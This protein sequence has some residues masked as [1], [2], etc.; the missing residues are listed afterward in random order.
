MVDFDLFFDHKGDVGRL[1]WTLP[2]AVMREKE[3]LDT[4]LWCCSISDPCLR[5]PSHARGGDATPMAP[6][7][8][9]SCNLSSFVKTYR[10]RIWQLL[11]LQSLVTKQVIKQWQN[12]AAVASPDYLRSKFIMVY[13]KTYYRWNAS[14]GNGNCFCKNYLKL[15]WKY[16]DISKFI[17]FP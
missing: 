13:G 9:S 14:V 4:E 5:C 11:I 10:K 2:S 16:K 7:I 12:K 6:Q 3:H 1:W 8:R 17:D 15:C